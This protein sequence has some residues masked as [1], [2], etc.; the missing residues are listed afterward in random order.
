M[1][2]FDPN[3]ALRVEISAAIDVLAPKV[4]GLIEL[5]KMVEPGPLL[6]ALQDRLVQAQ[7]K[8]GLMRAVLV[9]CDRVA[10]SR[11]TLASTGYPAVE[12]M[13]LPPALYAELQVDLAAANLAGAIFDQHASAITLTLGEPA[14][15]P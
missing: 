10:Q 2:D 3:P 11:A 9:H 7:R 14:D 1:D 12:T 8:L 5:C 13:A 4:H 6:T 15:K